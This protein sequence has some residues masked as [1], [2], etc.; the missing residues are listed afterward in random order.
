MRPA[1][2]NSLC[3]SV[4]LIFNS[5]PTFPPTLEITK[6]I[7]PPCFIIL[8]TQ[9]H[10]VASRS[11]T[12]SLISISM[13]PS[14]FINLIQCLLF[15]NHSN[16]FTLHLRFQHLLTAISPLFTSSLNVPINFLFELKTGLSPGK[17]T[18][19][20][21]FQV[22]EVILL[23]SSLQTCSSCCLQIIFL[24]SSK[25]QA[26]LKVLPADSTPRCHHLLVTRNSFVCSCFIVFLSS[27]IFV[28]SQP[29]FLKCYP[30]FPSNTV[31]SQFLI[32]LFMK[33]PCCY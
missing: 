11:Y 24:S 10:P 15:T 7:I 30:H 9:S 28:T 31:A 19:L 14:T 17:T 20:A 32:F 29:L 8:F 18:S 4:L 27:T 1:R 26:L 23:H 21:T 12:I 25:T 33:W 5:L 3:S 2:E 22:E 16:H 6:K 13:L